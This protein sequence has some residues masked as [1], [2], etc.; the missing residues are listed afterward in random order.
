MT[1]PYT[2]EDYNRA[3]PDRVA[4]RRLIDAFTVA[5]VVMPLVT[6]LVLR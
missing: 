2:P 5:M 4:R 1:N 6:W 3:R